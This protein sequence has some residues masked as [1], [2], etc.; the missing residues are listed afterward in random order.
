MPKFKIIISDP[1]EGKANSIELEGSKA[2]PLIG[3]KIGD[4]LDGSIVGLSGRKI[5]ITGGS[6]GDGTPMKLNVHG[7][8]RVSSLLSKGLG[9]HPRQKGLRKRKKVR[10]NIITEDI[11]QINL[12]IVS[13]EDE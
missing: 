6:D 1:V 5:E 4:V 12:K 11:V 3:N 7:G 13:K 9:Y 8:V 10:G 2:Q